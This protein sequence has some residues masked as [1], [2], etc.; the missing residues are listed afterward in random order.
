MESI[1]SSTAIDIANRIAVDIDKFV[2]R[3]QDTGPR[4]HLGASG[5]GEDCSR[6]LWYSFRWAFRENFKDEKNHARVMRLF[7]RGHREEPR[8]IELLQGIGAQVWTHDANGE[9]FKITKSANGH[10]G[11]SIDGI[12]RLPP[13]YG[14][15]EPVLLEFKTN[16]TGAGFQALVDNGMRIAK[17]VHYAQV[18]VYGSDVQYNLRYCLYMNTNKN[19]DS[20]HIELVEL[21]HELGHTLRKK[22]EMI[23]SSQKPPNRIS[24]NATRVPCVYCAAREICHKGALPERNCRSCK[25]SEPVADGQWKCH[26]HN[27]T[28][29]SDV[30]PHAC[31]QYEPIQ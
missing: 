5:I 16:G 13:Q 26:V 1:G 19:D 22:A 29:P 10:F 12:A 31:P 24:E 25:N 28:I 4:A 21:N 6:K 14:I 15:E 8:M 18:C 27:A 2:I 3:Q 20:L 23:V 11:G 9:Q 30:I 7:N 17:P